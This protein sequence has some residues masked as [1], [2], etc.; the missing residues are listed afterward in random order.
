VSAG[1]RGSLGA[2]RL[3]WTLGLLFIALAVPS[4]VLVL[5]TLRQLKWEAFHQQRLLAVELAERIDGTLQRMVAIEEARGYADYGF[6]IVA[7]DPARS[8]LLQRS[9]LAQFPLPG[10]IPGLLGWFQVDP[11]GTFSSPLL[12]E[13]IVDAA[14]LGIDAGELAGRRQV[15]ERLFEVLGRHRLVDRRRPVLPQPLHAER[16]GAQPAGEV[17]AQRVD[18]A[19]AAGTAEAERG[20]AT[21]GEPPSLAAAAASQVAF[22]Q[23]KRAPAPVGQPSARQP[24]SGVGRQLQE[25]VAERPLPPAAA[26]PPTKALAERPRERRLEQAALPV[27]ADRDAP[28]AERPPL[29]IFDSEL[30]PFEVARL[31]SGH[32]VLFRRV[33][34]S[35][36]RSI[37]GALIEQAAFLHGALG[38][39]FAGSALA[40]TSDLV[41]SWQGEPLQQVAGRS[42]RDYLAD[43]DP[44]RGSVLHHARLSAPWAEMELR[45]SV[46]TLPTSP[47]ASLVGW[48][49]LVLFA[50]LLAGFAAL[51]RLGLRQL[52]LAR[53]QQDFVAAVSHELKTPLTSIRMYA[54]LLRAGWASEEK[55]RE[56]YDYINDE[57]ERLSRLI[58]NV[59]Q[60][61]RL[62]RDE[63]RLELKSF[64]ADTLFELIRS[65][66]QAPIERAGFAVQ[67]ERDPA[68]AGVRLEVD[69]DALVQIMINL[70][71]NA[72]KFSASAALRRIEIQLEAAA[73]GQVVFT[74]RDHGPGVPAAARRR[75][76][77]LF[78]RGGSELT[79]ETQGTGIGLALARQLARGMGGDVEVA[80]A[81]PGARFRLSLPA[82]R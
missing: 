52:T 70:V 79:R 30:D 51:Y 28:A 14:A 57:S 60:L 1:L 45:W 29:R 54:E 48:A 74:V 11:A 18:D 46:H 36:E 34:R 67:F 32:F 82:R 2:R 55:K 63:L 12:P 44:L 23:L 40:A 64:D 13:A 35:G 49:G 4:A 61:A 21:F 76:F 7:G 17:A 77:E 43:G 50:V 25:V 75:I 3:R 22:D 19:P 31:D 80:A 62:E 47:G 65:R 42:G 33:W 72:L 37:Q 68:L 20:V 6:L 78:V 73:S 56:Y 66:V 8:N 58:A 10:E 5:Q 24:P 16:A 9:P 53:Q 26:S 81:E 27:L 38:E 71:D 41:V 69:A 59:L 15:E 39:P